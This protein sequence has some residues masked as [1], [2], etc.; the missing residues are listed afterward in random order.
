M[1]SDFGSR[2]VQKIGKIGEDWDSAYFRVGNV[3]VHKYRD[4]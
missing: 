2:A 1:E 3:D 4:K